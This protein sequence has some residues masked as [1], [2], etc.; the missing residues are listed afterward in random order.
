MKNLDIYIIQSHKLNIS[1]ENRLLNNK[2]NLNHNRDEFIQFKP[3]KKAKIEEKK[4]GLE[5]KASNDSNELL[6]LFH[7]LNTNQK[8]N[9]SKSIQNNNNEIILID[10]K[11]NSIDNNNSLI[12]ENNKN[13]NL[14][15]NNN[16]I[17]TRYFFQLT[18]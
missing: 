1:N 12:I 17:S 11:N 3:S 16:N 7:E 4:D 18:Q 6:T 14:N 9:I 10:G 8:N 13:E 15:N 2:N 5:K